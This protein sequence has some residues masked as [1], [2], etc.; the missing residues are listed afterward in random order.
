M[1]NQNKIII[2]AAIGGAGFLVYKNWDKISKLFGKKDETETPP[3][4]P[5]SN[6]IIKEKPKEKVYSE[7]EQ[8]VMKLQSNIGA[9]IDGNA[10]KSENS[11]TNK[12]TKEF[13]PNTYAK[14]GR[15]T[16]SNIDAYVALGTKREVVD[17]TPDTL[18]TRLNALWA[19]WT[20]AKK[21]QIIRDGNARAVYYDSVAKTYPSTG[22]YFVV[23][24]GTILD[25]SKSVKLNNGFIATDVQ[26]YG[27]GTGKSFG[28]RKVMI[29][30][31]EV[32]LV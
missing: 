14:L 2:A 28:V 13:F 20:G 30:P 27:A 24:Q 25:K 1:K 31:R 10:G 11:Q 32:N 15:V 26:V 8:K 3:P 6:E 23:K 21:A 7:Y 12:L 17:K 22:T 5:V 18:K 19:A 29:D 9:G 16:P 4:P